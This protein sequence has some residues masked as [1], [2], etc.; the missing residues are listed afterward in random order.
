MD[1][2]YQDYRIVLLR[3]IFIALRN[4]DKE[5]AKKYTLELKELNKTQFLDNK[6]LIL[7]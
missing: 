7:R 5:T 6:K 2:F 4:G 3:K 1:E